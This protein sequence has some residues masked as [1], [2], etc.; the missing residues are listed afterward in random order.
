MDFL[1]MAVTISMGLEKHRKPCV[2]PNSPPNHADVSSQSN[3]VTHRRR[4]RTTRS[5]CFS[6]QT[7]NWRGRP[8]LEMEARTYLSSRLRQPP[9][10]IA[11][12][13]MKS[14]VF[15]LSEH[16]PCG[17]ALHTTE[18]RKRMGCLTQRTRA[19][20]KRPID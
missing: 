20:D 10:E 11:S 3:I 4:M 16:K 19:Y 1:M 12:G 7:R 17:I 13:Q 8:E 9:S 6:L 2:P 14:S 5:I 15:G 18:P